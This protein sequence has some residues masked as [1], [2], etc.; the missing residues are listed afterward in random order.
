M[1][2]SELVA[3]SEQEPVAGAGTGREAAA[4]R[5]GTAGR[6]VGRV[7]VAALAATFVGLA[8]AACGGS[9]SSSKLDAWAKSVCGG[10]AT[11]IQAVSD[12]KADT[13]KII[14]GETPTQL[15]VR[16]ATDMG[17]LAAANQQIAQA[18]QAAGAP[19]TTNGAQTQADAVSELNQAAGGFTKVQQTVKS[20]PVSDQARFAAEL[21]GVSDQIGQLSTQSSTALQQLQ[22]GDLGAALGRQSGCAAPSGSPTADAS[23]A[24]PGASSSGAAAAS[25]SASAG[26]SAHSSGKP[27]GKASTKPSASATH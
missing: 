13:G 15:Q 12:A 16:L 26:S 14:P 17:K 2:W 21:R 11:P 25:G 27:S 20:L 18:V 22:S 8:T 24:A 4:S 10:I 23:T 5:G 19:Q 7:V 6:T 3:A 9:D 1:S